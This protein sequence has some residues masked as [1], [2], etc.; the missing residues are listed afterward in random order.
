[1]RQGH[2]MMMAALGLAALACELPGGAGSA[3]AATLPPG[4]EATVAAAGTAGALPPAPTPTFTPIPG[5]TAAPTPAGP[6]PAPLYYIGEGQQIFRLERDGVTRSQITF[7]PAPVESFDVSPADGSVAYASG[8]SLYR[9]DALGAGR[10]TLV[11]GPPPAAPDDYAAQVNGTLGAVRWSPDGTRIAYGLGGVMV[12]DVASG[13]TSMIKAS[14]PYP[15]LNAELPPGPIEFYAPEQ[16]SPDG[17][18]LLVNVSYFPE[19]GGLDIVSLTGGG[20]VRLSSPDGIVCCAPSWSRDGSGIYFASP[21]PG[22]IAS[23]LWRA[24]ATSGSSVTLIAGETGGL[25]QLPNFPQE[26]SDGQ[27]Y[28][29][30]A[31]SPSFPEGEVL[32]TMHRSASDGVTGRTALRS[33]AH[34]VGEALWA[35]DASGA[36]I[37][38]YTGADFTT[39]PVVGKLWWLPADGSPALALGSGHSLRWG[40]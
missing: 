36:A 26:L 28:F 8:N 5:P 10:A 12:Y 23:G 35:M 38:D 25:F 20:S 29:F 39:Y 19:A 16:W 15:D 32:L 13:T 37:T 33:D 1:M 34:A 9:V 7:E 3:P 14:S 18:R 4:A 24:D 30:F 27:L 2:L 40:R 17:S 11:V 22:F 21:V 6:L 31:T